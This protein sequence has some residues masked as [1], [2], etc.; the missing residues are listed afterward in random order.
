MPMPSMAVAHS[1]AALTNHSGL[2]WARIAGIM[3]AP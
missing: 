1:S 2:C 3:E